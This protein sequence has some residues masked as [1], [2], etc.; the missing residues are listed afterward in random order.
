MSESV[1]AI[2]RAVVNMRFSMRHEWLGVRIGGPGASMKGQWPT[3]L[4][5]VAVVF[6]CFFALGRLGSASTSHGD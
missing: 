1:S 5:A 2:R 3:L 4:V 6:A